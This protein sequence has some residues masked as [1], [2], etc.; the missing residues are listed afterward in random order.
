MTLS[1]WTVSYRLCNYTHQ[2]GANSTLYWKEQMQL[3]HGNQRSL[4]LVSNWRWNFL[5]LKLEQL[6]WSEKL[7]RNLQHH[8]ELNFEFRIAALVYASRLLLRAHWDWLTWRSG[9]GRN[10]LRSDAHAELERGLPS[11]LSSPP[12]TLYPSLLRLS[13]ESYVIYSTIES[14][15]WLVR[16]IYY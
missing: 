16:T 10:A 6:S 11:G 8:G 12:N 13:V 5:L 1:G 3:G 9:P 7:L 4:S 15:R 2:M 14:S